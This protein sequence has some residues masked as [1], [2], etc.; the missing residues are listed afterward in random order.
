VSTLVIYEEVPESLTVFHIR[1]NAEDQTFLSDEEVKVL[2]ALNG[3]VIN[4]DDVPFED[5][6]KFMAMKEKWAKWV[7]SFDKAPQLIDEDPHQAVIT[8]YKIVFLL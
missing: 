3:K 8:C 7:V 4:S 6:E 2:E 1:R 5:V